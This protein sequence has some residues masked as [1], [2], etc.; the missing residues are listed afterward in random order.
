MEY[1]ETCIP[2]RM[3]DLPTILTV[4]DVKLYYILS[5]FFDIFWSEYCFKR[6]RDQR[7]SKPK[8]SSKFRY[9]SCTVKLLK[10]VGDF[11]FYKFK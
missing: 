4:A 11:N 3:D 6:P 10:T 5:N 9:P 8:I 1:G 2:G 7:V